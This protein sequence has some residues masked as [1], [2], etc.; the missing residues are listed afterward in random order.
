MKNWLI[1]GLF[2]LYFLPTKSN[3]QFVDTLFVEGINT[4][5]LAN[6]ASYWIDSTK[7]ASVY[8]SERAFYNQRFK[9]W[10]ENKTL[11]LGENPY[12]L[13]IRLTVKN[14][15]TNYHVYWW[16]IYT[17]ADTITFYK[18]NK[19]QFSLV[20]KLINNTLR[21]NKTIRTRFPA[22][23]I[24]L[25]P[26]QTETYFVKIENLRN[27]QN[28]ITD[29]TT[30]EHNLMWE[31]KFYWQVGFFIGCFLLIALLSLCIGVFTR[32]KAFFFYA[33]YLLLIVVISLREEIMV[34]IVTN[35]FVFDI[36][37]KLHSLPCAII[38][39]ALHF[40]VIKFIFY[41]KSQNNKIKILSTLTTLFLAFGLVF[42]FI[43]YFFKKHMFFDAGIYPYL[44]DIGV[45]VV[46]S[47][48]TVTLLAIV[49]KYKKWYTILGA[50]LMGIVFLYYNPA[51]YFL[52]YAG[53]LNYYNITYPNYFYWIVCF[54]F[55]VIGCFM[56]W[57]YKR[58]LTKNFMLLQEKTLKKEKDFRKKIEIQQKERL[59]VAKDLHDDLGATLSA[60]K[61]IVTNNHQ[62]DTHLVTLINKANTDL[63]TF[64][65]KLT[66]NTLQSNVD[67]ALQEKINALNTTGTVYFTFITIGDASSLSKKINQSIYKICNELV[68]NIA[69]H[70]KSKE[71]TLQLLFEDD[72][73]EILA[74][75]AGVGFDTK[76]KYAGLGLKSIKTRIKALKGSLHIS[77]SSKGSTFIIKIPIK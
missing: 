72:A 76:K 11:N 34:S 51:G 74:E 57:R 37:Y 22:T 1:F 31:K 36:L 48:M 10:D 61:L 8:D 54:E 56:A 67:I 29:F 45:F 38:A 21:N 16:G 73:V 14:N 71:A 41:R 4:K 42:L 60:V 69:K 53:I 66:T 28:A 75:D 23:N 49:L 33:L 2:L 25:Q 59:E 15:G 50:L 46:F 3:T 12:P 18:K 13:W 35:R 52:N 63:K 47:I 19:D 27:T 20:D 55:I 68:N 62:E 9:H 7:K 26:N 39:L 17:Q 64:F 77:S 65:K 32:E 44:W 24:G 5:S 43:F 40:Y 30:P 6:Y 58:T 70:S